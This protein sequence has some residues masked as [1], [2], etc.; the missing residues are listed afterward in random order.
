MLLKKSKPGLGGGSLVRVLWGR[1]HVKVDTKSDFKHVAHVSNLRV[2]FIQKQRPSCRPPLPKKYLWKI[3][4]PANK[5]Q[6]MSK[7][8]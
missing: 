1:E 6:G 3:R 2:R 4:E 5:S 7:V 8:L